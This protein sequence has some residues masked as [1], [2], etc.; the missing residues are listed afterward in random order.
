M[1]R[2]KIYA[3]LWT[4]CAVLNA[5][6]AV[7]RAIEGRFGLCI[8]HLCVALLNLWLTLLCGRALQKEGR[9]SAPVTPESDEEET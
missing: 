6:C 2:S 7:F 8:L 1:E 3:L 4:V 9:E 5:V